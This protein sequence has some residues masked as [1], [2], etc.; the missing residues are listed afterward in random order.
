M[1]MQNFNQIKMGQL[2]EM[3]FKGIAK[4]IT[5]SVTEECNLACRYCYMTGKN[6]K[7]KM[8]FE[9]AKKTVDYILSNRELFNEEAVVWE[10]VG[11]EPFIEIDLIDRISDYIK[12]QM[13]ILNHPWFNK[14]MF[15]F[16]TN[17]LLYS[18][19][20]VQRYIA[21]NSTHISIGISI[22]GNKIKHDLQRV[23]KDGSGSYDDVMKSVPLWLKQ[24]PNAATKSTFAHDDLP[25]LKDSIIS[26][27]N[28]GITTVA[29][30]VVF[31][32][33]WEDG[34]DKVFEN[35][36][37]EL[38]DYILDN[39]LWNDYSVR[40]FNPTAGHP[41]LEDD[42]KRNYCGAGKMLAI[43]YKGDF[44]PCLRFLD[45]TLNNH[46]GW[47]IGN[48]EV[49]INTDKLRP[50]IALTMESQSK[51]ECLECEVASGCAWCTGCNYD[52]ADTE[53]IF[54]RATY[55]CKMHKANMRVN[56]YF[57]N[58]FE[59]ISGIISPQKVY[60]AQRLS[61]LALHSQSQEEKYLLFITSDNITPH[62]S[63]R[64]LKGTQNVMNNE[65]YNKGLKYAEEN[66]YTPIF[67]GMT[68]YKTDK[69]LTFVN[70]KTDQTAENTFVICDNDSDI[71]DNYSGN[72]ILLIAKKSIA[73]IYSIIEKLY[74]RITRINIILEEIENWSEHDIELYSSELSKLITF[75]IST[76]EKNE[77]I[78]INVLTDLLDLKNTCDCGAGISS[79]ALAPNGRLYICP[80][81]YFNNEDDYIGT[82]DNII[83]IKNKQLLELSNSPICS[84]CDAYHC[85]RCKFLDKK[86]TNEIHIP[87]KIQCI[88][89]HLERSKASILQRELLE[90]KLI[91]DSKPIKELSY[92]DPIE[93][94]IREKY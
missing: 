30:N 1:I 64:N 25:Y 39:K 20:K 56:T 15:S 89:S 53:T 68:K 43:D 18:T 87:S 36:L 63:Y 81:F 82:L 77:P 28:N 51:K 35:Q 27:W 47:C 67:L 21:K 33:V 13:Y 40:F 74:P 45:F 59:E 46:K 83:Q 48:A 88:I 92:N 78:E 49:G 12:Q 90:L 11:G 61:S 76:Y 9:T 6:S 50:F 34:D 5:F 14:Y 80:A 71:P 26:L 29:A 38:A 91:E 37:T 10:F 3:A 22:D 93:L 55:I 58:K 19:P 62:C 17:G 8:S 32:D 75:T 7:N 31:E 41:Y 24:F 52:L 85:R 23:K 94:C 70:G 79:L 42:F 57:W 86:L 54:Q 4:T 66:N 84:K 44:F 73:N 69:Y 16:A 60:R 72:I 2:P 65:I